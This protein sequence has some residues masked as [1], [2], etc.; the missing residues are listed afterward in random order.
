MS[1]GRK[2]K[3]PPKTL[4]RVGI[5]K[6]LEKG[7]IIDPKGRHLFLNTEPSGGKR[8]TSLP[9]SGKA[10]EEGRPSPKK[11]SFGQKQNGKWEGKQRGGSSITHKPITV[12]GIQRNN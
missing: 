5:S 1:R 6:E 10:T 4:T 11:N 2:N 3:K 9:Q 12:S 8:D 7:G